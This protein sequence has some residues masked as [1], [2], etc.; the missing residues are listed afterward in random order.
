M[1]ALVDTLV[2]T[3]R[4]LWR[5]GWAERNAG[6]ASVR[7]R[8]QDT[9]PPAPEA[10]TWRPI[11]A[12]VPTLARER[13]L[14]TAAGSNMRTLDQDPDRGLGLVELDAAGE[15]YRIAWGF[16]HGG[17]PTSELMPHLLAHAARGV[18]TGGTDRA[19][20][21]THPIHLIALTYA[22]DL[23]TPTLSRLLWEMHTEC[24]VFFPEGVGFVPWALP[25]SRAL[26]EA[27]AKV[28]ERRSAALWAHH[29]VAAAGPDL[30]TA[31][32]LIETAEK[33]AEIYLKASAAGPL[34]RCLTTEQLS[35]LAETFGVVPDPEILGR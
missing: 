6:N 30:D 34:A 23:D 14:L 24:I 4:D 9:S 21:H 35:S 32:G 2:R 29:G 5:K 7:L 10:A 22:L 11:G 20:L 17:L 33:A 25:G 28:L 8:P 3:A 27:T 18:A 16:T 15:A 13:F 12:A 1:D 19:I 26:A 31:F